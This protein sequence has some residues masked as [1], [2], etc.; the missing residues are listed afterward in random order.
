VIAA[1]GNWWGD[2]SGPAHASNPGG[3]GQGISDNVAYV[4]FLL[5]SNCVDA[6]YTP[7]PTPTPAVCQP[8][9]SVQGAAVAQNPTNCVETPT[10]DPSQCVG[11]SIFTDNSLIRDMPPYGVNNPSVIGSFGN[12]RVSEYLP[13][14]QNV[15][16]VGRFTA[17]T[18]GR[19]WDDWYKVTLKYIDLSNNQ[20][21]QLDGW[22]SAEVTTLRPS[23]RDEQC[24]NLVEYWLS[25]ENGQITL[26]EQPPSGYLPNEPL[27]IPP[28]V[29]LFQHNQD[30]LLPAPFARLPVDN[31]ASLNASQGY[32]LNTFA[33]RHPNFYES[34]NH[35]HSGL[36]FGGTDDI[37][38]PGCSPDVSQGKACIRLTPICDS[39]II[40]RIP[41]PPSDPNN[42]PFHTGA[43][44]I[45]QCFTPEGSRS[46][47]F[48]LYD[49][50]EDTGNL[51]GKTYLV[52]GEDGGLA[53]LS[54]NTYQ[55]PGND[56]PHLHMEILYDDVNTN[57]REDLSDAI[58]INPLLLF[59]A[60]IASRIA[61]VMGSYYPV[62]SN[63]SDG[64]RRFEWPLP[65]LVDPTSVGQPPIDGVSFNSAN[66]AYLELDAK[67]DLDIGIIPDNNGPFAI[68]ADDKSMASGVCVFVWGRID[69]M[70]V[71]RYQGN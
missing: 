46:R 28:A 1:A 27:P 9:G 63:E 68:L 7:T 32:G 38:A 53:G 66:T 43:K 36:D 18:P 51:E 4:N 29:E 54:L 6:I 34:V 19:F 70:F 52:A 71:F 30:L 5:A 64:Q 33:Y 50:L 11:Q 57:S 13:H 61:G 3:A 58:R 44:L 10:P 8:S 37:S 31:A 49:H 15:Q 35:I 60:N 2:S 20:P 65:D 39:R 12:Q 42:Q 17:N 62:A 45:F 16:I 23:Y 41:V 40:D 47:I 25:E 56:Y 26:I 48:V 67:E 55:Y 59:D 14:A 21:K 69:Q 22:A 24:I